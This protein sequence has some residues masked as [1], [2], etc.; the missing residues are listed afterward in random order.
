MSKKGWILVV[1]IV[2]G[3][4]VII[5]LSIIGGKNYM[6]NKEEKQHEEMIK[7]V[8]NSN[9]KLTNMLFFDFMIIV[10]FIKLYRHKMIIVTSM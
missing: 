10:H 5:T 3:L 2:G 1:S 7:I 8:Y 4:L 6:D 9:K